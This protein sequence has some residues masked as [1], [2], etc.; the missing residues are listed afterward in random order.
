M[1]IGCHFGGIKPL[2]EEMTT[3]ANLNFNLS[4]NVQAILLLLSHTEPEWARF[5]EAAQMYNITFQTTVVYGKM[6]G[7][8]IRMWP[9][10]T[11]EGLNTTVFIG[12]G[13]GQGITVELWGDLDLESYVTPTF[14]DRPEDALELFRAEDGESVP[15]VEVCYNV[16]ALFKNAYEECRVD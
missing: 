3:L 6:S 7:V 14:E 9:S 2:Y 11:P 10:L 4:R 8:C 1:L 15:W 13:P 16:Q 12:E 5:N